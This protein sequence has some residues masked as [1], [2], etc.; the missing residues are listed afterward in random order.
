MKVEVC[1]NGLESALNAQKGGAHR[2]E[3]CVD[4]SVGG[5]TPSQ[6]LI[7]EVLNQLHIPVHVLIRPR[8][9]N[10]VYTREELQTIYN[11][12]E[13]CRELGCTGVV[14]GALNPDGTLHTEAVARMIALSKDM[15]FTFH[16]AID[17]AVA[18]IEILKQLIVLGANRVLSSGGK[19]TA[20]EG[21]PVLTKLQEAAEEKISIMP[22]G[23][24]NSGN[25][26]AFS[27]H[28]FDAVHL[29]AIAKPP[30]TSLFDNAVHGVSDV[31]EIRKVVRI[32]S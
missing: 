10:F 5:L 9:G 12:I 15:E 29:S 31:D 3:L 23:G 7:E 30:S 13:I 1:A 14:S 28:G 2:I 21:L 6:D 18:P 8:G 26:Q 4:L 25:A 32:L 17:L 22:G 16:R 19:P 27:A 11:S 24:I 20:I